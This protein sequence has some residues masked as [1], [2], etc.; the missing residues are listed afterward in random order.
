MHLGITN[1]FMFYFRSWLILF[2]VISQPSFDH[3]LALT[4]YLT[5]PVWVNQYKR[6]REFV[7]IYSSKVP[8]YVPRF[9]ELNKDFVLLHSFQE[10]HDS[11]LYPTN[12]PPVFFLTDLYIKA[13]RT[14]LSVYTR[15]PNLLNS[16]FALPDGLRCHCPAHLL[17]DE[18]WSEFL[19]HFFCP[20]DWY[21]S[22]AQRLCQSRPEVFICYVLVPQLHFVN[23]VSKWVASALCQCAC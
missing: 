21:F 8:R 7:L 5:A 3:R 12:T 1:I 14:W 11:V 22:T 19:V 18:H 15:S 6:N 16:C 20:C 10:S 23:Q 4:V 2:I 13:P 17:R 9:Q